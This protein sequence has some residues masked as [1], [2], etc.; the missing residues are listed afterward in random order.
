MDQTKQREFLDIL[1]AAG[2][3]PRLLDYG[4]LTNANFAAFEFFRRLLE[5]QAFFMAHYRV[6]GK[7]P[8]TKEALEHILRASMTLTPTGLAAIYDACSDATLVSLLAHLKIEELFIGEELEKRLADKKIGTVL[9]LAPRFGAPAPSEKCV[10]KLFG[11]KFGRSDRILD[12]KKE[13]S[14]D[15]ASSS[16]LRALELAAKLEAPFYDPG[17]LP[18]FPLEMNSREETSFWN[19]YLGKAWRWGHEALR[20][21]LIPVLSGDAEGIVKSAANHRDDERQKASRQWKI[22]HGIAR[23][24]AT[25]DANDVE[26][27]VSPSPQPASVRCKYCEKKASVEHMQQAHPD[28]F[29]KIREYSGRSLE[30][31]RQLK[32][33]NHE[34]GCGPAKFAIREVELGQIHP[35]TEAIHAE[36]NTRTATPEEYLLRIEGETREAKAV[37][38]AYE[39]VASRIGEEDGKT[40]LDILQGEKGKGTVTNASK[41]I[42]RRREM[43]HRYLKEL[44]M[45]LSRKIPKN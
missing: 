41:S 10:E 20:K 25:N 12:S 23:R 40:F 5:I 8:G 29:I 4:Q 15:R 18:R 32:R 35:H 14:Q 34:G 1:D 37:T 6:T 45:T 13:Y 17:E 7:V 21:G 28:I 31:E 11:V 9:V 36:V 43:G 19:N 44:K 27:K 33:M 24:P 38:L 26:D 22:L 3:I 2:S 30:R 16:Y 39:H 42:G